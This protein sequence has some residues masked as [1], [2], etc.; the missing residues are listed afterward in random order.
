MIFIFFKCEITILNIFPKFLYCIFHYKNDI[1]DFKD[2]IDMKKIHAVVLL[3]QRSFMRKQTFHEC[4]SCY[5]LEYKQL[6]W[7]TGCAGCVKPHQAQSKWTASR[8]EVLG[9]GTS[10]TKL[11]LL[12]LFSSIRKGGNFVVRRLIFLTWKHPQGNII[13]YSQVSNSNMSDIKIVLSSKAYPLES[14][15]PFDIIM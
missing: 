9:I 12:V 4:S 6:I 13:I 11:Q 7:H 5:T 15:H 1:A 3:C 14:G 10:A 8:R 2:V